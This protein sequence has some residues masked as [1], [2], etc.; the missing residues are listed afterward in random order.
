MEVIH[1][2]KIFLKL[3]FGYIAWEDSNKKNKFS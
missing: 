1:Q 2:W 3:H